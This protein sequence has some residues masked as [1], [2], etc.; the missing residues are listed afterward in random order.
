MTATIQTFGLTRDFGSVRALD[1][2]DLSV[3]AGE[4]FGFL[5]PNG[6]GKSTALRLMLDLIRPTAGRATINGHDCQRESQ[7]VRAQV[8]Q[9]A[10]EVR[11]YP[12]LTGMQH[13][14][15]FAGLRSLELA[16]S[17]ALDLAARLQLNLDVR[18]SAY[19]KG[20]RQ[21]LG[22]VLALLGNPPVLLLDEPSSGLDPL[23]QHELWR[24]LR[25]RAAAG[26]TV[27]FSSHV[28]SEVEL[29][30]ERVAILR[31][32]RLME[33]NAVSAL[34]AHGLR[35]VLARFAAS[36]P[37]PAEFALGGVR[38]LTRTH[39]AVEFEVKGAIR[40][41]LRALAEFEVID[42][43]TAQPTLEELLMRFYEGDPS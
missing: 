40:P 2:L 30:C 42:L 19:S 9:L 20:N 13:F 22:I 26:T 11:L 6:A 34:K 23:I 39:D 29:V 8:G 25:E 31:S 24:I 18:A 4:I 14:E 7:R 41:L 5:G 37:P 33:V 10:G 32:G 28:M 3:E 15:L 36:A 1:S 35:H 38:E 17:G 27:F 43:E 21:K 16:S 12:S